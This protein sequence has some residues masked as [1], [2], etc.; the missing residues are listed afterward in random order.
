MNELKRQILLPRFVDEKVGSERLSD[1]PEA[2]QLSGSVGFDPRSLL[3]LSGRITE[4]RE[5]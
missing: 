4:L 3:G 5:A 2:A 1:L